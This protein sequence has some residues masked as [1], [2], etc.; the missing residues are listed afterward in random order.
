MHT[1]GCKEINKLTLLRK[2]LLEIKP[3]NNL[4]ID[5]LRENMKEKTNLLNKENISC[6]KKNRRNKIMKTL[7]YQQTVY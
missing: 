2:M 5:F 6:K 1:I 4:L 3:Y 7:Q